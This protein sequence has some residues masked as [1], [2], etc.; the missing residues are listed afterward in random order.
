MLDFLQVNETKP[1]ST[2][3]LNTELIRTGTDPSGSCFFYSLYYPFKEFRE[4]SNDERKVYIENKRMELANKIHFEEWFLI[5]NGNIAFLQIIETMRVI[6]HSIPKLLLDNQEYFEKYD[7]NPIAID[8][9]FTLLNP[10]L[11]E[12][13]IL[14]Q[15]DMECSK[16]YQAENEESYL[17]QIKNTWYDIYKIKV[18][19]AIED[20][21]K[22]IDSNVPKMSTDKKSKV[23][24]KLS[25]LSYP[26]FDFV[27]SKALSDFKAEISDTKKWLNVF[28]FSSVVDYLN[29]KVNII[30]LDEQTG[31]PYEGM[32]LLYKKNVFRNENPFVVILY[33][34]DMHFESLGKKTVVNK[35]TIIQRLFKKDDPF[36]I[37]CLSYLEE[38]EE[39]T[40]RIN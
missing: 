30:I 33:F 32:K 1:Y 24:Q 40:T 7:V 8:I 34:K 27:T 31:M 5:Q 14:P 3:V 11:V 2:S 23:V 10:N 4:L 37:T 17:E 22:K 36:I 38:D 15:W 29:L 25:L 28:I 39:S 19:K 35:K 16:K 18:K 21:E 20:L 13:E 12:Q 26:I 6:M 9:L